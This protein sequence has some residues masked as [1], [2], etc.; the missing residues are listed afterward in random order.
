MNEC[1]LNAEG[2]MERPGVTV[3][4]ANVGFGSRGAEIYF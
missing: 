3:V 4:L 2:L 1:F